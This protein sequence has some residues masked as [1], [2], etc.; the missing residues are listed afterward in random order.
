[1]K[2]FAHLQKEVF[3]CIKTLFANT[4][5]VKTVTREKLTSSVCCGP[6][7]KIFIFGKRKIL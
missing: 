1:M 7:D 3:A 4:Q 6:H 5:N 2:P